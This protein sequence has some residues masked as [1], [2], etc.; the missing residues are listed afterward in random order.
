MS[1][2]V[3]LDTDILIDYMRGYP[4][5]VA[6]VDGTGPRA[7]V[8]VLTV[9]E[10]YAGVREAETRQLKKLLQTFSYYVVT[11]AIAIR[12]GLLR[13][14]YLRS[15]RIALADSLIAATA[16]EHRME[17]ATLNSKHFPMLDVIVPYMKR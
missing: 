17:M 8:S 6:F 3:L 5:A 9:S 15:H 4:E 16:Q 1:K 12:G 10:L 2:R 11:R 7:A 13:R 14:Q